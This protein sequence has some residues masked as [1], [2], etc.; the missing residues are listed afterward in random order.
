[1]RDILGCVRGALRH[2]RCPVDG[3][4]LNTAHRDG[5]GEND[6]KEH[7]MLL[8]S[9]VADSSC[10][11]IRLSWRLRG[12]API[13]LPQTPSAFHPPA[14]R[15]AFRRRDVRPQRRSFAR[16]NPLLQRSPTP[17]VKACL[18]KIHFRH[19]HK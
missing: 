11:L 12:G 15:N 7:F 3:A 13:R 6:R 19:A 2:V 9:I 4:R 10:A 17:N 5:D 18:T 8:K 14:Q 16:K 1:V